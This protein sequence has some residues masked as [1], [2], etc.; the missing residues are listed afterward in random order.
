M[1]SLIIILGH[2]CVAILFCKNANLDTFLTIDVYF[3]FLS[4]PLS[5]ISVSKK[6]NIE[7]MLTITY[8]QNL[9][10]VNKMNEK[11]SQVYQIMGCEYLAG[12]I[13]IILELLWG[14]VSCLV[15][16]FPKTLICCSLIKCFP[17]DHKRYSSHLQLLILHRVAPIK[18]Y[19]TIY[20]GLKT[21]I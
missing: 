3:F 21:T 12:K 7:T 15:F 10:K 16:A 4:S 9:Q 19:L 2:H 8:S 6:K 11:R 18:F 17:N 5:F 13:N 1:D 14:Q 20:E